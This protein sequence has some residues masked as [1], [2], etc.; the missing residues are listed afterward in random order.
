MQTEWDILTFSYQKELPKLH[1]LAKLRRTPENSNKD[2]GEEDTASGRQLLHYINIGY[3]LDDTNNKK[4][5]WEDFDSKLAEG[6]D[7]AISQADFEADNHDY[8]RLNEKEVIKLRR[9]G[10]FAKVS[11]ALFA[12]LE[13]CLK[14]CCASAHESRLNISDFTQIHLDFNVPGAML[15]GVWCPATLTDHRH[16]TPPPPPVQT[17]VVLDT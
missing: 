5:I 6:F 10:E 13:S 2:F 12:R 1:A 7:H 17:P 3:F 9:A 15:P 11:E 8:A 14:S 4:A 16:V